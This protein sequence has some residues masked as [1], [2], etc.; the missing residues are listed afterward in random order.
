MPVQK[1]L[2][3]R[4]AKWGFRVPSRA[5]RRYVRM[6][7]SLHLFRWRYPDLFQYA[8]ARAEAAADF[9]PGEF[10]ISFMLPSR[11]RPEWLREALENIRD[12]AT[13]P[14]LVEI[15]VLIDDDDESLLAIQDK[16]PAYC[17]PCSMQLIVGSRGKGYI[18]MHRFCNEMA[19]VAK[20]DY[21]W[22]FSDDARFANDKWF[23][24]AAA[25]R[26]R[27]SVLCP[28]T[29]PVTLARDGRAGNI[30]PA[31]HRGLFELTGNYGENNHMDTWWQDLSRWVPG[32][33][34]EVVAKGVMI[35]HL[36]ELADDETAEISRT[37][38]KKTAPIYYSKGTHSLLF[39]DMW[40]VAFYMRHRGRTLKS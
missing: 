20:G 35:E 29:N 15:I 9:E 6:W 27:L 23:E 22:F 21:L 10:V 25:N 2:P 4:I 19:A 28:P 18:D 3:S 8:K 34:I 30:F 38:F 1:N 24:V 7:F 37:S 14:E 26:D 16:L 11:A 40:A 17:A 31:V 33:P 13:H 36:R 12:T 39:R 5:V 32:G